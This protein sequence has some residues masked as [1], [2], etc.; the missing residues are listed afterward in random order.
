MLT[1]TFYIFFLFSEIV[2]KFAVG[3]DFLLEAFLKIES[4]LMF[5]AVTM[6]ELHFSI[7]YDS[8]IILSVTA[9][10]MSA[11]VVDERESFE[12]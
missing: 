10:I 5:L 1:P 7:T 3:K 8:H 12:F 6:L 11:C 2:T 9:N 4:F